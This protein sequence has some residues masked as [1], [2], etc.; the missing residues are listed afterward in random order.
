MTMITDEWVGIDVSKL[1]LDVS[2]RT[3]GEDARLAYTDAALA[4]LARRLARHRPRGVVIEATGGIERRLADSLDAAGLPVA[5]VN[6]RQVRDFARATGRL[7]KT[8]RIDARLLALYGERIRPPARPRA[9][10]ERRHMAA[11]V[12]RRR[13]LVAMR[14][15]EK[16]RRHQAD[17]PLIARH[18]T[19]L[20]DH[21]NTLIASLERDIAA[22]LRS[23]PPAST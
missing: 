17:D 16:T 12:T 6:P 14:S 18:I 15:A 7:A 1:W 13:Q 5:V 9:D 4:T 21:F 8:D 3:A 10:P 23:P 20:I 11:L 2:L 22:A 19:E